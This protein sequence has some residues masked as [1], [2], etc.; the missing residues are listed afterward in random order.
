MLT[1]GK[2][3]RSYIQR[4]VNIKLVWDT[5]VENMSVE[6]WKNP[7]IPKIVITLTR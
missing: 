3:K 2:F 4:K 5:D 1:I 7:I 6:F